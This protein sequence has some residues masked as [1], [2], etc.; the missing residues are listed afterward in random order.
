[1][2]KLFLFLPLV[3]IIFLYGCGNKTTTPV[4][5]TTTAT[6]AVDCKSD[7]NCLQR[8]FITCAPATFTMPFMAGSNLNI[9]V[10]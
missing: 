5:Q 6:P 4:A 8:N 9:E 1:M 7:M 2:K 10:V 3:G